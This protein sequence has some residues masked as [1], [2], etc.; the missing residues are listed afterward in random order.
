[1]KISDAP[2]AVAFSNRQIRP[3]HSL[4]EAGELFARYNRSHSAASFIPVPIIDTRTFEVVAYISMNGRVWTRAGGHGTTPGMLNFDL[5][6]G[7]YWSTRIA[8]LAAMVGRPAPKL[9]RCGFTFDDSPTFPGFT[10]GTTWNGWDNVWVTPETHAAVIAWFK[11]QGDDTACFED[12]V[13]EDDGLLVSYAY[14]YCT[15]VD[16]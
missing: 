3:A 4:E 5:M 2:L 9:W 15:V 10:D 14:G 7:R 8:A 13:P 12:L 16:L 1:M 6:E 11:A